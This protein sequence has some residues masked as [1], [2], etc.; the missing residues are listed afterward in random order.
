MGLMYFFHWKTT[1]ALVEL[2]PTKRKRTRVSDENL[3]NLKQNYRRAVREKT[4][5]DLRD[6]LGKVFLFFYNLE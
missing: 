4:R 6:H 3:Q 2:Y 1:E 5:A